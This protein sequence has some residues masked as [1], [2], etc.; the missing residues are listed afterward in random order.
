VTP[1]TDGAYT[2]RAKLSRSG[3]DSAYS[4]T[5]SNTIDTTGPTLSSPTGTKT[6]STT[7]TLSVT[8]NEASGTEYWVLT[9]SATPPSAAQVKAGQNHL[10]AA[11]L[12]AGSQAVSATGAQPTSVT[13]LTASTTYF[14]YFMHEDAAT[15]QSTVS[16][17]SSFTTDATPAMQ[18]DN[19]R[20]GA[21]IT[22]SGSPLLTAAL[23]ANTFYANVFGNGSGKSSGKYYFEV[24]L[25]T[26][27]VDGQGIGIA[28]ASV[29]TS[30]I[31]GGD[32]TSIAWRF[33]N[34]DIRCQTIQ[35][36]IQ[37]AAQGQTVC[38]AADL[39][40]RMIWFRRTGSTNWNNSG[41]ADPATNTGGIAIPV[42]VTFP[43]KPMATME[44][45]GD[46]YTFNFGGSA[47]A[48]TKPSGFSD[49]T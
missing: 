43:A 25:N 27:G 36:T 49:W 3:S 31:D 19:S 1:L 24:T 45:T 44:I 20:K 21:N 38:C 35:A 40:N 14:A 22:L 23:S 37:T 5:A 11:A 39:D 33:V 6:G 12:K 18:L 8:T 7:A 9:G 15:N 26:I 34:G 47:Y 32:V 30:E 41:T 48:L 46:N 10:G 2:Y 4:A 13:A 28:N 17:A 42:T 29:T 16:A